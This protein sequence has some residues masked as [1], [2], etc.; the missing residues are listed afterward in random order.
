MP[1]MT[2]LPNT[3][4]LQALQLILPLCG[5]VYGMPA[6]VSCSPGMLDCVSEVARC[7]AQRLVFVLAYNQRNV[8]AYGFVVLCARL[9]AFWLY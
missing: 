7:V 6:D 1:N 5:L 3:C 9:V 4:I 8:V 2:V